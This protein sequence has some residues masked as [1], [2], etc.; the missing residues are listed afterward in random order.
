M[1][2]L[3]S[4]LCG[5]YKTDNCTKMVVIENN[6]E[7]NIAYTAGDQQPHSQVQVRSPMKMPLERAVN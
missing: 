6:R 5:I 3:A 1:F 2:G 4:R 7:E